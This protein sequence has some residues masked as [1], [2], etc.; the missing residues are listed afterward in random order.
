MKYVLGMAE[1]CSD[2]KGAKAQKVELDIARLARAVQ[3]FREQGDTAVGY[4]IV[5]SEEV[6]RAARVWAARYGDPSDVVVLVPRLS[7]VELRQLNAE[8]GDQREGNRPGADPALAVSRYGGHL[9]ERKLREAIR[10]AEPGV[11]PL[12]C[13]TPLDVRWDFAGELA[14]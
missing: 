13:P 5:L 11:Q 3:G 7:P 1:S 14:Y 2:L 10:A 12:T 4:M 6:A 9:A 8:K